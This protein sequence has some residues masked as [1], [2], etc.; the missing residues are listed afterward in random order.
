MIIVA[1]EVI[2]N[3]PELYD[4]IGYRFNQLNDTI[5]GTVTAGT[6][7][8]NRILLMKTGIKYL[9]ESYIY[10]CRVK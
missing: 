6:S 1:L 3:V 2:I 7:T 10:R 8:G 5:F 9:D 4:L